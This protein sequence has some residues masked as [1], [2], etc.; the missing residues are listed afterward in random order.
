MTKPISDY[1]VDELSAKI[2]AIKAEREKTANALKRYEEELERKKQEVPLGVPITNVS[3]NEILYWINGA[4]I[5]CKEKA[6]LADDVQVRQ[7]SFLNTF[8]SKES[9]NKHA[10]MLLDWRKDGLV[11][12][13]KGEPI[14]IA[15]LLPLLK[16]G[17]VAMNRNNEWHWYKEKPYISKYYYCW[18]TGNQVSFIGGF[19]LKPAENWETS[20]MECGL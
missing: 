10:E 11:A 6:D 7:C 3:Q 18:N 15:V 1:T 12:N 20:L 19:N 17:W 5:P 2:E 13:S 8:H 16:K 4:G 14:D 9:A